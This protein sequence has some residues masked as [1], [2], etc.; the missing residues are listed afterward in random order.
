LTIKEYSSD[1]VKTYF[2]SIS[3]GAKNPEEVLE[4][5]NRLGIEWFVT[6]GGALA[7]KYWQ[8]YEGFVHPEQAA[9]IRSSMPCP[10]QGEQID[11][12]SKNLQNIRREFGGQWV[13]IHENKIATSARS[14]PELLNKIARIDKPL[15]TFIP[16]EPVVWNF[17]YDIKGF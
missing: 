8:F 16:A 14:L 6:E 7:I 13:A 4:D 15:V 1:D 10:E 3:T 12:L 11:W 9:I 2:G 5:L 17:T